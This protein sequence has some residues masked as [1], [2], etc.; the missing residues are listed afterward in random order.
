VSKEAEGGRAGRA[1][2]C[3]EGYGGGRTRGIVRLVTPPPRLP[4]PAAVALAIPTTDLANIWAHQVWHATKV[5]SEKPMM[6][7]K[8]M[9]RVGVLTNMMPTIAGVVPRR[10]KPRPLRAPN[11]SQIQPIMRRK[12]MVPMTAKVPERPHWRLVMPRSGLMY[13]TS[14]AA[15]KVE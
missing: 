5:A 7:R 15:A 4:Q 2:W 3:W 8:R 13:A 11:L 1:Q 12:K 14:D 9:K 6:Q 10:R